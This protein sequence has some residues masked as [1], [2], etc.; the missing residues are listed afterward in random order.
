VERSS[1]FKASHARWRASFRF[2]FFFCL[3]T[4]LQVLKVT[5]AQLK[6]LTQALAH[7]YA[8]ARLQ[9]DDAQAASFCWQRA[10]ATC[11]RKLWKSETEDAST[12]CCGQLIY[13][14][15]NRKNDLAKAAPLPPDAYITKCKMTKKTT[16]QHH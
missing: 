3:H 6:P 9:K 16:N 12:T 1:F 4:L 7:T 14:Y 2:F 15:M 11:V 8:T 13:T 5:I 10:R